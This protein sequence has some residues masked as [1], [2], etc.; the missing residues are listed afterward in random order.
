MFFHCCCQ[1]CANGR[2]ILPN[3]LRILRGRLRHRIIGK[4]KSFLL[5]PSPGCSDIPG[6]E[7][8]ASCETLSNGWCCS[9]RAQKLLRKTCKWY[10]RV[11][12]PLPTALRIRPWRRQL[13]RWRHGLS[14]L[15]RKFC[16]PKFAGTTF[17]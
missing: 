6:R 17:I 13:E 2:K 8:C 12:S 14:Y 4:K 5:K 1:P 7:T 11:D 10:C 3:W 9:P 16:W 15:K